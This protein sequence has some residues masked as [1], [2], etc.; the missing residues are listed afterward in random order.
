MA[1]DSLTAANMTYA[2]MVLTIHCRTPTVQFQLWKVAVQPAPQMHPMASK[3]LNLKPTS[4]DASLPLLA[5]ELAS[6]RSKN[7]GS[8]RGGVQRHF[9]ILHPKHRRPRVFKRVRKGHD[10]KVSRTLLRRAGEL[11][12][13]KSAKFDHK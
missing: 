9:A 12:S 2:I 5:Q 4:P 13:S 6:P 10:T 1:L 3:A 8:G 7:S 11:V